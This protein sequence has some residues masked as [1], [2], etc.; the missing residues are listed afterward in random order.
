MDKVP[1]TLLVEIT[2]D[3]HICGLCKQQFTNLDSFVGHKQSG[4]AVSNSGALTAGAVQF[5]TQNEPVIPP[6]T[7]IPTQTSP[8]TITSETQTISV[9]TPEIVFEHGYQ[10]FLPDED[11]EA[12]VTVTVSPPTKCRS[13]GASASV[14][15]R[16]QCC[17]YPGC[18]FK[19]AYGL[20]DLERHLRT[21]TGDKPHKCQTCDKAFS[22]KDKLKTHMRSHT[23]EKP[24]KCKECDYRAADSSSLCKHQRIHTNERPFK[25]Q[26]CPYASRNSSQLTVHLRS[27]TGDAP[28]QCVLCN[29]KFKINSD[30]KRHMR[31]HTGE[32]P[33]KCEFCDFFCA[34]KGNL[35]SHIR[36]KHNAET[37]YRCLECNYQCGSK[38]DLRQHVRCHLPEQPV[39]CSKCSY[40]CA[41]KAALKVHERIHSKDRPFKCNYCR[42]DTKQRSNLT[43]HIKKCHGE[44][45]K[46]KK[47]TLPK[48][49]PE[50]PCHY[51]SRST[52]LEAKKAYK[53]DL[54]DSSFVREDSL[55]SHKKQHNELL[56]QKAAGL[57][58]LQYRV[59]APRSSTIAIRNIKYP[60]QPTSSLPFSEEKGNILVDHRVSEGSPAENISIIPRTSKIEDDLANSQLHLLSQVNLM[61]SPHSAATPRLTRMVQQTGFPNYINGNGQ[62]HELSENGMESGHET[63]D[64]SF[65]STSS[66]DDCSDIETI[67]IIKEEPIEVTVVSGE[68]I[69]IDEPQP[70]PVFSQPSP[71]ITPKRHYIIVH[72][73]PHTALLCPADSIP[74]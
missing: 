16:K 46:P 2:T 52:K 43:T 22:R 29:A 8:H 33:F 6:Q 9:S 69:G 27:H 68:E 1:G 42:F 64:E 7:A 10:T 56:T 53:C 18:Q 21:H 30:L 54:C 11:T 20:K 62:L 57:D 48:N 72:E 4:C 35:K 63:H 59:N 37:T 5:I 14:S 39:K 28:F 31:V 32:K 13:R 73:E 41:S 50:S 15:R 49:E 58:L 38:A 40:S 55:R 12:Q 26:I 60:V 36:M 51:S 66:M 25:C 70:S 67:R 45:V 23:G 44:Q 3:I 74:D 24:F 47:S 19:T 71:V 17:T 34:M 61:A 65:I